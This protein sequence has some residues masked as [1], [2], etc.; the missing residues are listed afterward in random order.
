MYV[1][2]IY[3]HFISKINYKWKK[4][5]KQNGYRKRTNN[6]PQNITLKTEQHDPH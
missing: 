3:H 6:V 2:S 1:A 5:G 4:D